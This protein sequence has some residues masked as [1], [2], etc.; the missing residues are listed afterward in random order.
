MEPNG[1]LSDGAHWSTQGFMF[2]RALKVQAGILC[3][4][5][6]Q[7]ILFHIWCKNVF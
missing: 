5:F 1:V 6:Y 4:G 3:S 7:E 2:V